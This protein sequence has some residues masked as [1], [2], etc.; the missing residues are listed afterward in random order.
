MPLLF[1]MKGIEEGL[2]QEIENKINKKNLYTDFPIIFASNNFEIF[3][4]LFS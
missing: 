1:L 3:I 4:V 2:E